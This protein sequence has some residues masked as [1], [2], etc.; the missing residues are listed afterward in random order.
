[1]SLSLLGYFNPLKPNHFA[2]S[3]DLPKEEVELCVKQMIFVKEI[4]C[5]ILAKKA[6][7]YCTKNICGYKSCTKTI[8][9]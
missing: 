1:M 5:C 6:V 4:K 8:N 2:K 3:E 7:I 9:P